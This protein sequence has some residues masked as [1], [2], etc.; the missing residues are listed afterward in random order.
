MTLKI[1]EF[2]KKFHLGKKQAYNYLKRFK[3]LD[4][5]KSYIKA[6][7]MYILIWIKNLQLETTA[8]KMSRFWLQFSQRN[9][10]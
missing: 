9:R 5:L 6:Q 2:A 3:G 1:A 7:G 10:F 8:V 4:Y